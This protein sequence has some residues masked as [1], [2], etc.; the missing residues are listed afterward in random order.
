VQK[1]ETIDTEGLIVIQVAQ[2]EKEKKELNE[3]LRIIAKR[4]DH[5]E[6]AYRKEERP[7]LSQDY[8]EQQKSDREAFEVYQK[9][10]REA[11]LREHQENMVA[12]SRLARM[13]GDY[14]AR[15]EVLI[16][17]KAAEF[18]KRKEVAHKR[19]EE[20]KAKRRTAI[21]KAREE[22]RLRIEQEERTRR[23]K[24]EEERR[25]AAGEYIP[26]SFVGSEVF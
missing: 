15:K 3:R 22:E 2:L 7:L 23:A 9:A 25:I 13:K 20:E 8:E 10:H 18:T 26:M 14:E 6:R 5:V 1:L 19:M 4:V 11:S 16:S 21:I 24:E 12:K 17:K